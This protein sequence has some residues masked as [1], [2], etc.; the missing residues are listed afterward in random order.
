[1]DLSG[2]LH[3]AQ[4]IKPPRFAVAVKLND[5]AVHNALRLFVAVFALVAVIVKLSTD[6]ITN[7]RL[8]L[9]FGSCLDSPTAQP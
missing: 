6:G 9:A 7:L 8:F 5:L 2:A 4:F 1:M 3:Q